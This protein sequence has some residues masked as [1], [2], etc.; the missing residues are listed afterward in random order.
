M[1]I[2]LRKYDFLLPIDLLFLGYFSFM[3]VVLLFFHKSLHSYLLFV[4]IH[5][6]IVIAL[7]SFLKYASKSKNKIVL[8]FRFLYPVIFYTFIYKEL[9]NF[10]FL[11]H[12]YWMDGY[13]LEFEMKIFGEHFTVLLQRI[14]SP[15]VTEIFKFS[16]F[17]YYFIV[18]VPALYFYF[19]K[20]E[21]ALNE[22]LETITIT[23]FICYLGFIVFPVRGP[24]YEIDYLHT[25][26]LTGYWFTKIQ[27]YIM[28]RGSMYGGCMPSSHVAVTCSAWA[29]LNKYYKKLSWCIFPLIITLCFS[30]VYNRYHYISDVVCGVIISWIAIYFGHTFSGWYLKRKY[31]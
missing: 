6:L 5:T 7:F 14:V 12:D 18:F 11:I 23:F 25:I 27:N 26:D 9:D 20:K 15:I 16:Y 19:S 10:T 21:K 8:F 29:I 28:V 3:A 24:R 30:T 2:F 17:S 4:A 13:I 22:Y 31:Y 1:R